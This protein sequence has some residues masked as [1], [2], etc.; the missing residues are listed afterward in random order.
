MLTTDF[1]VHR[2]L[3]AET[4]QHGA[5]NIVVKGIKVRIVIIVITALSPSP[6]LRVCPLLL[7]CGAQVSPCTYL[8]YEY[9]L[10]F[11]DM[12]HK[13][14]P[15]QAQGNYKLEASQNRP[16]HAASLCS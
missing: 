16:L 15:A 11:S 12:A 3:P 5:H 8:D 4:R 9:A 6:R 14:P 13:H 1:G 7:G 10:Y 2:H